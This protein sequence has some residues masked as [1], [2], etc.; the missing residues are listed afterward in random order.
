MPNER[1]TESI[2]RRHFSRYADCISLEEQKSDN[3]K[4]DKLLSAASKKG[5]SKGRPDF[6][7]SYK[8]NS[9]FIIVI[10]CKAQTTAHISQTKNNYTDYAVDGALLYAAHLAKQFDVLAIGVSGQ[11]QK[12][13]KVSHYIHLKGENKSFPIFDDDLL[14]PS[15]YLEGYATSPQK[16]RQDYSALLAFTKELNDSLHGQK[17]LGNQRGL[18]VSAI[19]IALENSAFKKSYASHEHPRD[20]AESLAQTVSFELKKANLTGEK[21]DNLNTQFSFIK[22][23]TS[24]SQKQG[25]LKRIIDD[26][27]S[28]I[29]TFIKTHRYHDVLGQMYVEFLSYANSDKGL[30]IVLTPPHITD[31]FSDI[32]QVNK[33]SVVYDNCA[34]TGGFLISAM[35]KM[36]AGAKGD[37]SVINKIK[38]SRLFGV[39]YQAHIYALAVC[40]MFIHQDGKTNVVNGDCFDRAIIDYV[41]TK[42]PSAGFLNPPYKANKKNDTEELEFVLNNL[43]CLDDGGTCVAIVPM[44]SALAQKGV[45]LTLK[46]RLLK[47]HSLEGVLSMPNELFFNSNVGV[48]ACVMI[49]TAH[50]AHPQNKKTYF[51]YY[52]DD[53]HVKRKGRGRVD[54]YGVWEKVKE[55]W[56][57]NFINRTEEPGVSVNKAVTANMEWVAEA[58]METDYLSLNKNHFNDTVH[59]YVCFLFSCGQLKNVSARPAANID[60]NLKMDAWKHFCLSEIF[61]ITGTKTTPQLD[62]EE[63]GNGAYPYVT[64]QA[65]NNGVAGFFDFFTEKG[66]V[67]TVDS[68]V[69]GYCSYQGKNFSASDHVEKL[70]PK[71]KMNAYVALFL[72]TIVNLEQY[73]YNYGR[74][75]S[76][77][78]MRKIKIKL[79]HKNNQPD[80]VFMENYIKSLP[81]TSN[82]SV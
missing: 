71:F 69:V 7:I 48:V 52:K 11:A 42:H 67:L 34:G 23:D 81:Y 14:P 63:Y 3:P 73:R 60:E 28:N 1:K 33:N 51:G 13:L 4:I 10:E 49:F 79:P 66:N 59:K 40:N 24:L 37:Q 39:E 19:L 54:D 35:K 15:D 74:K 8:A 26:I 21:L 32:A 58:Y 6:I 25:V 70:V 61:D 62:L 41:R 22:T 80:V 17:I 65:T 78:R 68:A 29:N 20:V 27:D 47:K 82:L 53:G 76:Q 50:K 31:F 72:V 45:V 55:K 5:D 16:L 77:D 2:V 57:S 12:S 44:Q 38:S 75:S 56:L 30:G 9:D 36:I 46:E 43:D 64:T 18:L